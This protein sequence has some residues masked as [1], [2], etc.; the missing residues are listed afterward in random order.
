MDSNRYR[1]RKK[2]QGQY[3]DPAF[4]VNLESILTSPQFI[5]LDQRIRFGQQS[6]G[7]LL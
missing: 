2:R 5:Q 6:I 4:Y 7:L 3:R 1:Y